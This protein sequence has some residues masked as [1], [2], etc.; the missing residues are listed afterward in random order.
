MSGK[1]GKQIWHSSRLCLI[2]QLNINWQKNRHLYRIHLDVM[3]NMPV[4]PIGIIS[5]LLDVHPETIRVWERHGIIKPKRRNGRRF[6]SE[7]DLKRLRFIQKLISE[8]LNLPAIQY[9]LQLYPCWN[10]D[11]CPSCVLR[12][13]IAACTKPCW[14]EEGTFCRVIDSEVNCRDCAYKTTPA[15]TE[16][17]LRSLRLYIKSTAL[18]HPERSEGSRLSNRIW[19]SPGALL[20]QN[21]F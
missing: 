2:I 14:K 10:K 3:N 8:K 19:D 21:D 15:W 16:T 11:S 5:E 12:S 4:F 7:I 20:P 17:L 9:Y 1:S 6:Y 18:H 13:E